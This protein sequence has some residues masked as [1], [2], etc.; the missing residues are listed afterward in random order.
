MAHRLGFGEPIAFDLPVEPSSL[1]VPTE[2]LEFARTAAGFW[3]STLSPLAAAGLSATIAR[4]GEAVQPSLVAKVVSPT[5]ASIWT[6]PETT[7]VR[8]AVDPKT[9]QQIAEM[10][11]H[12]VTEGTSYRAFH[13]GHGTAFLPNIAVAGKTGTLTDASTQRYYTWFT[14]FAPL[15]PTNDVPQVAIATL[16]INGP[17]WQIKA[18]VLAR[19]VL[20]EY[21]AARGAEGVTQPSTRIARR[22]RSR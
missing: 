5:G 2:P 3:N 17:S 9:A 18:N 13:D 15:R 20:R 10:M 1:K 4:G 21:F 6:A 22:P 16:V 19:D 12:T 7:S 8:R 11:V 14:G